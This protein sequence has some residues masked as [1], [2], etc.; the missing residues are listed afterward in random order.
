MS[1]QLPIEQHPKFAELVEKYGFDET[2]KTLKDGD[3]AGVAFFIPAELPD[4][5]P[6]LVKP[7]PPKSEPTPRILL[8]YDADQP[9]ESDLK[10]IDFF[11]NPSI[12]PTRIS[13]R[14]IVAIPVLP[15]NGGQ[16]DGSLRDLAKAVADNLK[17]TARRVSKSHINNVRQVIAKGG[18]VLIGLSFPKAWLEERVEATGDFPAV[19][20]GE[21]AG[22]HVFTAIGYDNQAEKL[23]VASNLG[24]D[25]GNAG[26][27]NLPFSVVTGPLTSDIWAIEKIA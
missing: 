16:V 11:T 12:L 24:E 14:G 7:E 26:F 15:L 20:L 25:F 8:G 6:Q 19:A 5:E 1:N 10:V 27:G 4:A 21:S 22:R 2:T 9:D 17:L 13:L 23:I 18:I 3:A